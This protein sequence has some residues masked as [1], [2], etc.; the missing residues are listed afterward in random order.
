MFAAG[1]S[2]GV[3]TT[4]PFSNKTFVPPPLVVVYGRTNGN[5][6]ARGEGGRDAKGFVG[7]PRPTRSGEKIRL[8]PPKLAYGSGWYDESYMASV[9]GIM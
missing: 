1:V 3:S 8:P 5:G 2:D 9:L 4:V 6:G 7:T